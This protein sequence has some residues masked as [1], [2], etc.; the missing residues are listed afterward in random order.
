MKP[1]DIH[2]RAISQD[3]PQPW[4][5]KVQWHSSECNFTLRCLSH[6]SLKLA[7][8]LSKLIPGGLVMPQ[9]YCS[10]LAQVRSHAIKLQKSLT[11]VTLLLAVI[12]MD[13]KI[14]NFKKPVIFPE[15]TLYLPE[16]LVFP[17]ATWFQPWLG[18]RAPSWVHPATLQSSHTKPKENFTGN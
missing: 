18:S 12:N 1:S 15:F 16:I 8:K 2:I 17:E 10:T 5:T 11:V 6:Q 13:L 4:I 3:M 9:Q 7:W 14:L